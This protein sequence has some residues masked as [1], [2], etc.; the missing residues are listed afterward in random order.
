MLEAV[1]AVD[2]TTGKLA[3]RNHPIA[4]GVLLIEG[5]PV[6]VPFLDRQTAVVVEVELTEVIWR[7]I[8][9]CGDFLAREQVVAIR[10]EPSELGGRPA[11]FVA[12]DAAVAIAIERIKSGSGLL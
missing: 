2:R 1:I 11:P 12:L 10:V 6:P 8:R 3:W 5:P 9:R 7:R 4:V